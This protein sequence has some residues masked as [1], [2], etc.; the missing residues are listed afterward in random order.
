MRTMPRYAA[1]IFLGAFLLF[2]VQPIIARCILPWFGGSPSVWTT[3]MLF[4][5]VLLLAGY[6]YS[7]LVIDRVQPRGQAVI[8]SALIGISLAALAIMALA[9]GAPLLPAQTWKP[10]DSGR[11]VLRIIGL[12]TVTVGLPYLV[13]AHRRVPFCRLGSAGVSWAHRRTVCTPSRTWD[14][15]WHC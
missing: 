13:L 9:W 12:L 8:H 4:F 1:A 2:Q 7:H 3:C 15:C 5:Q 10:L 14:R 11:P 6:A